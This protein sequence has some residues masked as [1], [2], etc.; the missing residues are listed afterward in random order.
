VTGRNRPVTELVSRA[1]DVAVAGLLLTVTAPVTLAVAVA[2][3]KA[4][5]RPVLFRQIRA[6]RD[7]KPF[8][9]YKFRTMRDAYGPDGQPL[10]DEERV[11]KV[12]DVLRSWSLDELPQLINVLR[13]DMALV[14]P[15]PLYLDYLPLYSPEQARR[16]RVRP[17]VTGLVQ[18]GGRNALSWEEKFALDVRYVDEKSLLLDLRVLVLTAWRVLQR[19]GIRTDGYATAPW[20]TGSARAPASTGMTDGGN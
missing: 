17:G 18:V 19:S 11:T 12:G 15:R 5:G 20:F 2:V 6:G 10:S 3:R 1:L 7:G 13:G 9:I 16:L 8:T 4:M 14:G